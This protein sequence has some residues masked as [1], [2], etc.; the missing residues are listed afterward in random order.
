MSI[1]YVHSSTRSTTAPQNRLSQRS[2]CPR[3]PLDSTKPSAFKRPSSFDT[4]ELL[5]PVTFTSSPVVKAS[6]GRWAIARY[7]A[8]AS[9]LP[10]SWFEHSS[11]SNDRPR[12]ACTLYPNW[13]LQ[14]GYSAFS[15]KP[16]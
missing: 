10:N 12:L 5:T 14:F 6:L 3:R 9:N 1:D 13:K 8:S 15:R 11:S 4:V 7:R 2:Y 16:L